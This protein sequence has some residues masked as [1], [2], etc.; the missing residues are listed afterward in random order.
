[1]LHEIA[2]PGKRERKEGDN[3]R[4]AQMQVGRGKLRQVRP[5]APRRRNQFHG[6]S[7]FLDAF[8]VFLV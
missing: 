2:E 4:V 6:A 5:P 7:P 1:M 8:D 3:Q